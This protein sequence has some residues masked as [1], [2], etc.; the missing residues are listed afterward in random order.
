MN[1]IFLDMDGVVNS[2]ETFENI[3]GNKKF[4]NEC[5]ENRV[6]PEF[7]DPNLRE[8]INEILIRVPDCKVVW[9][10]TWRM[11]LRNSKVFIKGVYD[12]CGFVEDSFLSYTPIM[13]KF[14]FVEI[15]EWLRLFGKNY[16][17]EKCVIIDDDSDAGIP[18]DLEKEFG[19][20]SPYIDVAKKYNCKFFQTKN[21]IGIT[22]E[23]KNKI[24]VYF[25]EN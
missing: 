9:S 20:G 16:D 3:R 1:I 18:E 14:R 4:F 2:Q 5:L 12:T 7:I 19:K 24:L 22:D 17:I 10:S 21:E 8:K 13:H 6:V 23:I 11:G 15:L 25:L